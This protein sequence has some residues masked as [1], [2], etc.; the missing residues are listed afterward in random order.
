MSKLRRCT[1]VFCVLFWAQFAA[2]AEETQPK[3]GIDDV[4][5]IVSSCDKYATLWPSFFGCL[6]HFWPQLER[7]DVKIPIVL[8]AGKKTFLHPRVTVHQTGID[9]GWSANLLDVLQHVKTPYVLYLQEDYF[10]CRPV[11]LKRLQQV[12][13]IMRAYAH[14]AYCQLS[15]DV[16]YFPEGGKFVEK[17]PFML[18]G[19]LQKRL[20]ARS[21]NNLQAALWRTDRLKTLLRHDENPWQFEKAGNRRSQLMEI[22]DG[23]LF[24]VAQNPSPLLY[25]N[26]VFKGALDLR[27]VRWLEKNGLP[28]PSLD[29]YPIH[30]GA[31]SRMHTEPKA[32]AVL[33]T[34]AH[35]S[36]CHAGS[37]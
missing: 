17:K 36:N 4:T 26:G 14:V 1:A 20:Y 2:Y 37:K 31:Y 3:D 13:D 11:H 9:K 15:E 18:R 22:Q 5:L 24:L 29:A 8:I 28:T 34:A 25:L 16:I 35:H 23:S 27:V 32:Y 21:R 12:V 7:A 10:L 6:F 33:K 30:K 19:V